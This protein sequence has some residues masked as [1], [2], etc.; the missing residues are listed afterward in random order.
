[1]LN[2]PKE[3]KEETFSIFS[4]SFDDRSGYFDHSSEA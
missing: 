2:K 1:L 4:T 3:L